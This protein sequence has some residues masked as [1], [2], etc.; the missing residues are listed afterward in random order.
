MTKSIGTTLGQALPGEALDMIDDIV[1]DLFKGDPARFTETA[2]IPVDG[3]E[4]AVVRVR[5]APGVLH[6][7][8]CTAMRAKGFEIDG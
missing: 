8:L 1:A 7:E 5:L 6:N 4:Y 3:T 2:Y